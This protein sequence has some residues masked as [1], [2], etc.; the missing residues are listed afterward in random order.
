MKLQKTDDLNEQIAIGKEIVQRHPELYGGELSQTY[1][2][3]INRIKRD[4]CELP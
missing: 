3:I 1:L 4:I 2:Q